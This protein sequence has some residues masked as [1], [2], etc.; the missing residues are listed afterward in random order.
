MFT[1]GG[2]RIHG[3]RLR[4][5]LRQ[6]AQSAGLTGTGGHPLKVVPHQLRH[7]YAT[8]LV[9]AGMSLPALMALLGHQTPEM[10]LRYATLASPTLRSAYDTA[11]G[12]MRRQFTLTPT[13]RPIVPDKVT[14]L[15]AEMLKTR[16][17]HGYCSRDLAAEACP[18]ANI[19]ENCETTSPGPSSLPYSK[20][21]SSTSKP[22]TMTRSNVAGTAKP[23]GTPASPPTSPPPGK[24]RPSALDLTL[25]PRPV[26]ATESLWLLADHHHPGPV[27]PRALLPRHRLQPRSARDRRHPR[28]PVR[29][30]LATH[31]S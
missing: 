25:T 20:P 3:E 15:H 30:T 24:H 7:T 13:G 26:N 1:E 27:L 4:R 21:N 22:S 6:A 14:W 9:N 31:N 16:V 28:R 12:K 2:R 5:G 19:C 23:P 10:T 17:P 18:Y 29:Q 11:M 8:T